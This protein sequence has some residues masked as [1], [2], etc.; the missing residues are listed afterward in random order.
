MNQSRGKRGLVL[1]SQFAGGFTSIPK[2]ERQAM[3]VE[4]FQLLE[5]LAQKFQ[6]NAN[7]KAVFGE[8]VEAQGKTI[9]PVAKIAYGLGG[10]YGKL[11]SSKSDN[12]SQPDM[13]EGGGGGIIARPIGV[14]EITR[15]RTRFIPARSKAVTLMGAFFAGM[16]AARLIDWRKKNRGS[17]Q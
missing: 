15:K 8:P 4:K 16:V 17:K 12:A 10:G 13:G 6:S 7:V 2:S 5:S 11:E 1:I 3:A 9:I 14:V